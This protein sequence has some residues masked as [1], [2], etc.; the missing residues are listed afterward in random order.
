MKVKQEIHCSRYKGKSDIPE[1]TYGHV[2]PKKL[3]SRVLFC[4]I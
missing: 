3:K 1:V 4:K 2:I